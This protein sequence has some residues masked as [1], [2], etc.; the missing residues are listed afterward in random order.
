MESEFIAQLLDLGITGLFIGYLLWK[1]KQ[2][3]KALAEFNE[4][5]L[6]VMRELEEKREEGYEQ[7]R[8]RY[9]EVIARYN[10]ERDKLLTDIS[11]ALKDITQELKNR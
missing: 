8:D 3:T 9:D 1:D 5:L 10:L 11:L 6:Q 2:Q 7:I 4:K